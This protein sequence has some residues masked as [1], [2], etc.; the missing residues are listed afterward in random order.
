M[1]R[2]VRPE[3]E[4][5]F[6]D[7]FRKLSPEAVRL[8]FFAPLKHLTHEFAARLTQIDYDREMALVALPADPNA[9]LEL[10]G[11]AR[12]AADPDIE[13]AEYAVTVRSDVTGRGLSV[14]LMQ[15]LIAY[16]RKRGLKE[17]YSQVLAEN[18]RMLSLARRLGF[19]IERVPEDYAVVMTRLRLD[20]HTPDQKQR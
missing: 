7:L 6:H 15:C 4:P 11:V 13:R 2:P 9:P 19:A 17:L 5:L 8:R 14:A 16:A 3:D 1:L 12:F 20:A 18:R 10:F